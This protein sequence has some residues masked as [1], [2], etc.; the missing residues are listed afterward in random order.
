VA[1]GRVDSSWPADAIAPGGRLACPYQRPGG[2]SCVHP[3]CNG[4]FRWFRPRNRS[5]E[6]CGAPVSRCACRPC[7]MLT[8]ASSPARPVVLG[9]AN[10]ASKHTRHARL[11]IL[12]RTGTSAAITQS[13]RSADR[14]VRLGV[15]NW[16]RSRSMPG[17][18]GFFFR[19]RTSCRT[20]PLHPCYGSPG[21]LVARS[22]HGRR[23]GQL[24]YTRSLRAVRLLKPF[25]GLQVS[26]GARNKVVSSSLTNGPGRSNCRNHTRAARAGQR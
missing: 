16:A 11:A 7:R 10:N 19:G 14:V 2:L 5:W 26:D 12:S 20:A 3:G 8:V 4:L 21:L 23:L 17:S 22:A 9:S 6:S 25:A 1:T 13:Y 15:G 24:A 18:Y